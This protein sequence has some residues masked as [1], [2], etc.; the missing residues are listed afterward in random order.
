MRYLT[1]SRKTEKA[2]YQARDTVRIPRA[3]LESLLE[4][5]KTHDEQEVP[6]VKRPAFASGPYALGVGRGGGGDDAPGG[7][8]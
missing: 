1:V 2:N 3:L 4:E 6:T 5:C 8:P 7:R